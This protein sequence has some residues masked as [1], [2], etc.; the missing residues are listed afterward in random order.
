MRTEVLFAPP[1]RHHA[2]LRLPDGVEQQ[3][4]PLLSAVGALRQADLVRVRVLQKRGD[5]TEDRIGGDGRGT[6]LETEREGGGGGRERE[7]ERERGREGGR[8][9]DRQAGRQTDGRTDGRT[10]RH[11]HQIAGTTTGKTRRLRV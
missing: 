2:L 7:R 4:L 10:D 3:R 6:C 5:Q 9:T 11:L 8:Q 1:A